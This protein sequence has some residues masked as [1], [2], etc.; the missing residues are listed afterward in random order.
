[1]NKIKVLI[2]GSNGLLGQKLVNIFVANNFEVIATSKGKNRN[3][4][5]DN[6]EYFNANITNFDKIYKFIKK[7]KPDFIINTAAMTNVDSCELRKRECKE[8]NAKV[9]KKLAKTCEEFNIHLI[10]ISTDFVFK[11]KKGYYTEN[12]KPNPVNYYGETKLKSEK[13]L[14]KYDIDY[15]ILRTIILYGLIENSSKNNFVLWVKNS[16]EQD[17][18]INIVTDQY[19]MPTYVNDLAFACLQSVKKKAKGIYHISSNK[20]LSIYEMAL[21]IANTFDLNKELIKPILTE[22][23]NQKAIRPTKTGFIIDKAVTE[24]GLKSMSFKEQLSIFKNELEN[25]KNATN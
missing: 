21:E 20:L 11:G 10:Q 12:D 6:Y 23:L 13:C 25:Q 24:L 2:T 15:T 7:I 8:I 1:M 16:L 22:K 3:P 19:R 18:S 17:K 4:L 9:I 5:I 14:K